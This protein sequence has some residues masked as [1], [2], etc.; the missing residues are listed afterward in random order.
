MQ[1][2]LLLA[3]GAD[4]QQTTA[5]GANAVEVGGFSSCNRQA[6]SCWVTRRIRI[7]S[8][9]CRPPCLETFAAPPQIA[10]LK[11]LPKTLSLLMQA[12]LV[13]QVRFDVADLRLLPFCTPAFSFPSLQT[14]SYCVF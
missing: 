9:E 3:R 6:N 12:V 1:V 2:K 11:T 8:Y 10:Q 4:P 13:N 14:L 5:D 7:I